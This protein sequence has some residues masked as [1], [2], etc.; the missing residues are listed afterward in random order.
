MFLIPVLRSQRQ[1]NLC[2]FRAS[3]IYIVSSRTA[4]TIQREPV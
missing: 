2:E 3:L 1:M 4:G